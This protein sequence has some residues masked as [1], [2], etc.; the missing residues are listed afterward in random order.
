MFKLMPKSSSTI[1]TSGQ[2]QIS[3]PHP[4]NG[5]FKLSARLLSRLSSS[6]S[7]FLLVLDLGTLCKIE[8]LQWEPFADMVSSSI[9]SLIGFHNPSVPSRDLYPVSGGSRFYRSRHWNVSYSG[10]NV[11]P[12]FIL[13]HTYSRPSQGSKQHGETPQVIRQPQIIHTQWATG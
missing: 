5:L 11:R 4:T 1:H 9:L 3:W 2:G 7:K 13:N 6:W 12:T 10:P 8:A